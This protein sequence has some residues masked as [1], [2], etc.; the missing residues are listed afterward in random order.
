MIPNRIIICPDSFKGTLSSSLVC[1]ILATQAAEVFPYSEI[2][3]M[4]L[5]DGGEGSLDVVA[6]VLPCRVFTSTVKSAQ[7]NPI[8]AR[9]GILKDNANGKGNLSSAVIEIAECCGL[10]C[11]SERNPL[12]ASTYGVGQL[13]KNVYDNNAQSVLLCLGGSATTDGGC[14]MAAAL[15]VKFFNSAKQEFIPCGGTLSQIASIDCS[16]I[17]KRILEMDITALCDVTNV[18]FGK[19]GAAHVFAAQKGA[20]PAQITLL[21]DGLAHF[22][23]V[24]F[25]CCG[26]DISNVSGAGAAGGLGAGAIAFLDA[27]LQSG[28]DTVLKLYRFDAQ[29]KNADLI[30]FGEGKIDLQSFMGKALSGIVKRSGKTP[31]IAVCGDKSSI[32]S[33]PVF[34]CTDYFERPT[35]FAL[36]QECLKFAARKAFEYVKS[37]DERALLRSTK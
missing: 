10:Y 14:G 32:D 35:C 3:R 27:K 5:A 24:V 21:D 37:T 15:G 9:Y 23:K 12:T 36:P 16:N 25:D 31:V 29:A 30:V 20:T 22:A 33:I 1:D 19:N 7:G 17:D 11:D 4:P 34:A 8:S 2:L 18:L 26:K 6:S 13:I 28:I